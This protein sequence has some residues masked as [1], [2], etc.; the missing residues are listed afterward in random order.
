MSL[1]DDA[2]AAGRKGPVCSAGAWLATLTAKE[3]AEVIEALDDPR[4][5][6]AAL[7][8]VIKARWPEAPG[9]DPITRHRKQEC[10]CGPR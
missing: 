9:A 1:L 3:R 5:T 6:H 7:A 2:M 10:A 8:R 4:P